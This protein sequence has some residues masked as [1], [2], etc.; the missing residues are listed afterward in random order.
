[1]N[2]RTMALAQYAVPTTKLTAAAASS[3]P[4]VCRSPQRQYNRSRSAQQE[5]T[6]KIIAMRTSLRAL[7]LKF[8][9]EH[10]I[11]LVIRN[12]GHE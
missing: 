11:H 5:R 2:A 3:A 12:T 8:A 9:D 6:E 7:E 10:N 4:L 1:M